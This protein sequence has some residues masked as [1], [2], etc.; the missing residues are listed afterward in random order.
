MLSSEY[1]ALRDGFA[2][3]AASKTGERKGLYTGLQAL[4]NYR[5]PN[6]IT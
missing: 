2:Q 1:P 5:Q 4:D 6:E 3:R